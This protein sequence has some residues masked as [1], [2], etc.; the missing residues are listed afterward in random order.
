MIKPLGWTLAAA[1]VLAAASTIVHPH[2]GAVSV[3]AEIGTA[4][5]IRIWGFDIG[6]EL[7]VR[8]A[9]GPTPNAET[10]LSHDSVPACFIDGVSPLVIVLPGGTLQN[11]P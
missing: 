11:R 4:Q 9:A 3:G 5:S 8:R 6:F 2:G 7:F 1:L 10:E